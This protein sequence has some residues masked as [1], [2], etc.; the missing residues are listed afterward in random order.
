[1]TTAVVIRKIIFDGNDTTGPFTFDFPIQESDDYPTQ[2]TVKHIDADGVITE[3]DSPDDF[4]LE[5]VGLGTEGGSI[6]LTEELATG[7]QLVV[8]GNTPL[9]QQSQFRNQGSFYGLSHEQAFDKI[10]YILQ[11]FS[12]KLDRAIKIPSIDDTGTETEL[13]AEEERAN[14][15]IIFDADGNVSISGD[16]YEDQASAAAAS[17]A[18]AEAALADVQ[19]IVATDFVTT[20]ASSVAIGTGTKT[21]VLEDDLPVGSMWMKFADAADSSN[22]VWGNVTGYVSGTKT[23]TLNAVTSG[24]SGT[25]SSWVA[26]PTGERGTAGAAGSG[27]P[28]IVG[29]DALKWVRVNAGESAYENAAI[30]LT[31]FFAIKVEEVANGD[32]EIA[33]KP[34]FSGTINSVDSKC[35]S[36]TCTATTKVNSTAL[37]GTANSV[38]STPQ[39]QA[40]SSSNTFTSSDTIKTTISAN[41]A[42]L[43]MVLKVNYTRLL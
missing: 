21:F 5:L 10:T 29:G 24:G 20:S 2:I 25:K 37:G 40:H 15:A 4:E 34:N 33:W 27:T 18:A 30:S 26:F 41:S 16:D 3:L 31:D 17:A 32:Y 1:M 12:D 19:A 38:S 22:Y 28:A 35:D 23:V 11:E 42:C 43:N 39:N 13:S 9:E 8:E 6:T 14:K 36:G 7:E